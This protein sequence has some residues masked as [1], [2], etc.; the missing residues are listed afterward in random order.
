MGARTHTT[1]R[2]ADFS[3]YVP[4][5]MAMSSDALGWRGFRMEVVRGHAAGELTLPP[6][7]HHLLNLILA[8]PTRHTHRW[9]GAAAEQ[10]AYEGA[11]SLVPAGRDSY[12]RWKYLAEGTPCDVHLHLDPG[13][14][15]RVAVQSMSDL[16]AEAEFRGELC[17]YHPAVRMLTTGLLDEMESDGRNGALYAESLATALVTVLLTMQEPWR[18][19][20]AHRSRALPGMRTVCDFIESNLDGHLHLETLA[21]MAGLGPERFRIVFRKALGES[22]HRYV[23]RRRIERAREL[24]RSTPLPITEIAHRLGF[25]DHSHLTSTFRRL[26]GLTPS[27]FRAEALR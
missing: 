20:S 26:T 14:V 8:V 3:R 24:L 15:R 18:R 21:T 17:F 27:R 6:L 25:A 23:L 12:W 1:V 11:A 16:P 19:R 2:S 4:Y 10:T 5:E 7:D 22:P 9:D 13:F